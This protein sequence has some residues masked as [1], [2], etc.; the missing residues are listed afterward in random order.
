MVYFGSCIIPPTFY[1]LGLPFL[2]SHFQRLNS[3]PPRNHALAPRPAV[4]SIVAMP[5]PSSDLFHPLC[6]ARLRRSPGARCRRI[7]KTP[8]TRCPVHSGGELSPEGRA[9]ISTAA[10]ARHAKQRA[11][12][13]RN[14]LRRY[15]QG[16]PKKWVIPR[17][18][19]FFKKLSREQEADVIR[20]MV[21]Y[22]ARIRGGEPRPPWQAITSQRAEARSLAQFER[23]LIIA[24]NDTMRPLAQDLMEL[25]YAAI[26][27]SEQI[28]ALDGANVRLRR[29]A[30]ERQEFLLR[31]LTRTGLRPGAARNESQVTPAT[32]S[33]H[34]TSSLGSPS[35]HGTSN[36]GSPFQPA[37]DPPAESEAELKDRVLQ[38]AY[39]LSMAI[40]AAG[41]A[42]GERRRGTHVPEYWRH[43]IAPWLYGR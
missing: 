6:G 1:F 20:S 31:A 17:P 24:M 13:R 7:V 3:R 18:W 35:P 16:R 27:E 9:V 22:D 19:R 32:P 11:A 37:N 23:S 8:G 25:C 30:W 43:T 38:A 34:E 36:L 10:R 4:L 39:E 21:L 26:R 40:V 12:I 2:N 15:P 28:L 14:E 5:N 42:M 41:K 33:P 29:L